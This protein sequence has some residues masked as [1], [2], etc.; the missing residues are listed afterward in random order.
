MS[1]SHDRRDGSRPEDRSEAID[2]SRAGAAAAGWVGHMLGRSIR[3]V[4]GIAEDTR[5]AYQQGLD[6]RYED[7]VILEEYDR[8]GEAPPSPPRPSRS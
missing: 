8:D 5:K 4:V 3:H 1:R 2:W 7:A 6:P